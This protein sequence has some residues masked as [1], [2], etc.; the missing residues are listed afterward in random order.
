MPPKSATLDQHNQ[1]SSRVDEIA[2][3]VDAKFQDLQESVK[4]L[5]ARLFDTIKRALEEQRALSVS[6]ANAA[7]EH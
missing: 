7:S 5:E 1:L 6:A 4:A 3:R 2:L